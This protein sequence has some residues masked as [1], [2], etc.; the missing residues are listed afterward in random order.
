MA[1][2]RLN[3]FKLLMVW[4]ITIDYTG[5]VMNYLEIEKRVIKSGGV[6]TIEEPTESLFRVRFTFKDIA[7]DWI[8]YFYKNGKITQHEAVFNLFK[9]YAT[10]TNQ[11]WL[12]MPSRSDRRRGF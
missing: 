8:N 2:V 6:I 7:K 3:H 12:L 1:V 4:K 9:I 10:D 11:E 5:E